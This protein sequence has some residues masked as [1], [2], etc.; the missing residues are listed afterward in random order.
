MTTRTSRSGLPLAIVLA[1]LTAC[2]STTS[3]SPAPTASPSV[4]ASVQPSIPASAAP[5]ATPAPPSAPPPSITIGP[6][7]LPIAAGWQLIW[8]I[9]SKPPVTLSTVVATGAGFVAAGAD[10]AAQ[11]PAVLSS[12]DGVAWTRETIPGDQ[13]TPASLAPWGDRLLAVGSGDANCAHPVGLDTWVRS[14]AGH[15][16]EAPFTDMLCAASDVTV[17]VVGGTVVLAGSGPGDNPIVWSSTDGLHWTD[18]GG[19]FA[20]RFPAG[21]VGDGTQAWV[22]GSDAGSTWIARTTNGSTWT[23]PHPLDGIPEVDIRGVFLIGDHPLIVASAASVVETIDPGTG[24]G[25]VAT[26]ASGLTADE[27]GTVTQ[28]SGGLLAT[29]GNGSG[30]AAWVSGDGVSWR[31]LALPAALAVDGASVDGVAARD[32][33]ALLIGTIPGG[34]DNPASS[35]WTGSADLLAP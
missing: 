12:A 5:S 30:A 2:S 14:A 32:G 15:W 13:R 31:A 6:S 8:P 17:A 16:T 4:A 7:V 1:T 27:L 18:R 19:S 26:P 35:I 24:A 9:A 33:R 28:F 25:W 3:P 20:G 23:Q 22:L 21:V 29:G 11:K 34:T 10:V